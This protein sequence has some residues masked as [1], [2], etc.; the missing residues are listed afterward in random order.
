MFDLQTDAM[1]E[2]MK[3][4]GIEVHTDAVTVHPMIQQSEGRQGDVIEDALRYPFV[5]DIRDYGDHPIT[6]PL[7]SLASMF[8]PVLPVKTVTVATTQPSNVTVT[9]II[10]IPSM[11][12]WGETDIEALRDLTAEIKFDKDKDVA[13]PIYGGAVAERIDK[14][15]R[16]VVIGSARFAYDDFVT[17][18]DVQA[19]RDARRFIARFPANGELFNNAVFWL[20]KMESMM[21][22]SPAAMDVAR[23]EPMSSGTLK[24][25]QNGVLLVLLP[26]AVLIAGALVWIS[27]RD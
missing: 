5:F 1:P 11:P 16:L 14:G 27:R 8:L 17:Q 10:P 23:I 4:W 26:G 19:S 13:E 22:I 15:N 2:V 3:E 18:P 7:K 12:S 25:W 9:P 24:T 20:A 21:A 6:R